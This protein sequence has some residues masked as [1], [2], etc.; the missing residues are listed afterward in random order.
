MSGGRF[1]EPAKREVSKVSSEE[2]NGQDAAEGRYS[3]ERGSA[4]SVGCPKCLTCSKPSHG[5]KS[6]Q[7]HHM[8]INQWLICHPCRSCSTWC[9]ILTWACGCSILLCWGAPQGLVFDRLKLP[10]H[11]RLGP[12][13]SGP[14]KRISQHPHRSDRL[15]S[16]LGRSSYCREA[17]LK[18]KKRW[19]SLS[20]KV[21]MHRAMLPRR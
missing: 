17:L 8:L 5:S 15:S 13:Q 14:E 4:T 11:D 2:G 18:G 21:R 12:S 7:W 9:G 16:R 3:K 19:S 1:K 20:Q 10:V 6:F